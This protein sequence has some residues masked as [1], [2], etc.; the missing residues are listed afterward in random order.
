MERETLEAALDIATI[1]LL[2]LGGLMSLAAGIGLIRF[3]D[4]IARMHATTKPQ[5]L[6]L[7]CV[8]IAIGL[9]NPSWA[10]ALMLLPILGFQMATAPISAHMVGRAGYRTNVM[11]RERILVDELEEAIERAQR[12][13]EAADAGAR[14]D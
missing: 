3:P 14:E 10:T 9:Q 2:L 13:R 8:L 12:E 6:G 7:A 4:A 1:V 5:V 11:V